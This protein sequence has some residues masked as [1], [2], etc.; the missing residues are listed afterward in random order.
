[1]AAS[2]LLNVADPPTAIFACND[3]MAYGVIHAATEKKIHVPNQLSIVGFDDIYLSTYSNPPLTTIKQPRLEMGDEA[4]NALVL[5][6]KNPER[7]AR[8]NLLNAEL[9]VRSSTM[10]LL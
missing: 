6:M 3:L 2:K 1:L 8:R 10:P 7:P 9:V 5:L 4:V